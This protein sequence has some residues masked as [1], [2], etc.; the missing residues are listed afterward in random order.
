MRAKPPHPR[1]VFMQQRR[2][3]LFGGQ[4]EPIG[5]PRWPAALALT[6]F[7]RRTSATRLGVRKRW[8]PAVRPAAA[9]AEPLRVNGRAGCQEYCRNGRGTET[10]E[11]RSAHDDLQSFFVWTSVRRP[12]KI[13]TRVTPR[14]F[15][16]MFSRPPSSTSGSPA[17]PGPAQPAT[18]GGCCRS[19]NSRVAVSLSKL[20]Q[21][22]ARPLP[23]FLNSMS[24]R[25]LFQLVRT[26]NKQANGLYLLVWL[27]YLICTMC[28]WVTCLTDRSGRI[29]DVFNR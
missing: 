24:G 17:D 2:V 10:H 7:A 11:N 20:R 28:T 15:R 14:L 25:L 19:V 18:R 22:G 27:Y 23:H 16:A 8:P 9:R 6:G 4:A 12:L 3:A 26:R 1:R 29:G 5:H 21:S 13:E